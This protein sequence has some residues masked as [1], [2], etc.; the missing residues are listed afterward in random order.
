MPTENSLKRRIREE[1]CVSMK[2][3][4][5]EILSEKLNRLG[6]FF[7]EYQD[8]IYVDDSL[9]DL[10]V[11]L[12]TIHIIDQAHEK[13]GA[14]YAECKN[15]FEFFGRQYFRQT[16]YRAQKESYIKKENQVLYFLVKGV[17]KLRELLGEKYKAP[18]YVIK[19]GENF[20]GIRFFEE[21]LT[22][23]IEGDEI[24]LCDPYISPSTLYPFVVLKGRIKSIKILTT[25]IFEPEK[26]QEYKKKF[27]N[28]TRISVQIKRN[29][30]IHDRYLICGLKAWA[31]GS[32]IKDLG[33]KDTLIREISEIVSSLTEMFSLR[34]KE[35][36]YK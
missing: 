8:R 33:N 14:S 27:E 32:S 20:S 13:A 28:E 25:N 26:F 36:N 10:D 22:K 12:L 21:F 17:K 23:E 4:I 29:T 34:W 9:S 6:G 7:H 5:K 16:V 30:N 24:L 1:N 2:E 35:S 18:I 11:L 19:A 31:I 3:K 15:L